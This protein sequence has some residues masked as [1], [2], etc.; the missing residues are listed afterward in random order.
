MIKYKKI[1]PCTRLGWKTYTHVEI[2]GCIINLARMTLDS[3]TH[4]CPQSCSVLLMKNNST[5]LKLS[6]N[7]NDICTVKYPIIFYLI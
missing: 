5:L 2:F 1:R 6:A 3:V 4:I 7:C